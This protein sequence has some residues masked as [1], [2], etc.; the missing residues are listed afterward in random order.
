[1]SS[2]GLDQINITPPESSVDTQALKNFS[3][4]DLAVFDT[5]SIAALTAYSVGLIFSPYSS[6][7]SYPLILSTVISNSGIESIALSRLDLQNKAESNFS[8][9]KSNFPI[10]IGKLTRSSICTCEFPSINFNLLELDSSISL[11]LFL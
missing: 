9:V 2:S 11:L 6:S 3:E 7:S 5:N 1:L 4:I 10:A 8:I